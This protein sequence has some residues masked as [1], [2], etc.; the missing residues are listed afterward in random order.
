MTENRNWK[1][2]KT[3]NL[4]VSDILEIDI[5]GQHSNHENSFEFQTSLYRY[6]ISGQSDFKLLSYYEIYVKFVHTLVISEEA[7]VGRHGSLKVSFGSGN[8]MI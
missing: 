2:W 1:N 3:E 8:Y 7:W 6:I 4:D 5:N